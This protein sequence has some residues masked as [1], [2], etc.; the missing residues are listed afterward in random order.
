MDIIMSIWYHVCRF[1]RIGMGSPDSKVSLGNFVEL[2]KKKDSAQFFS[3]LSFH[4]YIHS[5][6]IFLSGY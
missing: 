2:E 4:S 3:H 6:I 5:I 1:S